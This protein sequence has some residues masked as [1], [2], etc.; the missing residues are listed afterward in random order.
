[1][2]LFPPPDY[3]SHPAAGLFPPSWELLFAIRT[4]QSGE[5]RDTR[6]LHRPFTYFRDTALMSHGSAFHVV[7]PYFLIHSFHIVK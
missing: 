2:S 5:I 6:L 4:V 1:M 7:D 3:A